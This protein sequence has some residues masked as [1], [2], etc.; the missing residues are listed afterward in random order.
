MNTGPSRTYI[1]AN[2]LPLEYDVGHGWRPSPGGLV[3]ALKPALRERSG[4]WVGWRGSA[5]LEESGDLEQ[6]HPSHTDKTD[7][8][9]VKMTQHEVN[10]FY[11]RVC[12]AAIWPLYHG[13]LIDPVFHEDDLEFYTKINQ[14]FADS[15]ALDAPAGALVWVHD[16]QLQL[17][18][19]MLREARPDLR[20]GF[21]LHVPFPAPSEFATLPWCDNLLVGLLGADLIGFQTAESAKNF[22]QVACARMLANRVDCGLRLQESAG[23]R[24]VNI[25][26][27]PAGPDTELF[28]G[29]AAS[30]AVHEAA[31]HTRGNLSSPELILLGVDRLDHTKGIEQR[32]RAVA[33]ILKS[34]EFVGRDVLFI[35]V[36]VPTRGGL[37]AYQKV[38]SEVE[39]TLRLANLEL[40]SLGLRPI[41]YIYEALPAEQ[42]A[43]LYLAADVMLVT[44]LADGMNLVCKEYVACRQDGTGRLVLSRAAGAAV[45]LQDAWL[46]DPHD[47]NDVKRGMCE[48]ILAGVDDA[49]E[50]M[51]RL[52]KVVF[53]SDAKHWADSFLARLGNS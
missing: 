44:S 11:D 3:S 31:V 19:A 53:D 8:I 37:V 4:V 41:H 24:F 43:A 42:L 13:S 10:C 50:R 26:V 33:D 7:I 5:S 9:E 12:N 2:R 27:F 18:P 29:F 14:R 51:V 35:Q 22:F 36:A 30:P 25:D 1:I 52:R 21:F 6:S 45:Q 34:A 28:A 15:V 38:R 46:V 47:F 40:M 20:I 17:V 48:A 39:E 32:I 49:R 16:Y 23:S